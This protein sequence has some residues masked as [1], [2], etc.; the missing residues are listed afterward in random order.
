MKVRRGS[1][2]SGYWQ[3]NPDM[4]IPPWWWCEKYTDMVGREVEGIIAQTG[5]YDFEAMQG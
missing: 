1:P 4:W 2:A 5:D 3:S